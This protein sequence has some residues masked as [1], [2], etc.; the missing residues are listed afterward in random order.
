MKEHVQ[1]IRSSKIHISGTPQKTELFLTEIKSKDISD[2]SF[3]GIKQLKLC[4]DHCVPGRTDEINPKYTRYI[5]DYQYQRQNTIIIQVG[6]E[7][8]D[9]SKA[10][11][12]D[13]IEIAF[14]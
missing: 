7:K 1:Y 5:V 14:L 13:C 12:P 8:L 2:L 4:S 10:R 11:I 9:T 3:P 6:G